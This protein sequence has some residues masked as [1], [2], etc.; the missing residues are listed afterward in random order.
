MHCVKRK[1]GS[2]YVRPKSAKPR[3]DEPEGEECP[4]D[5]QL[6]I[7]FSLQERVALLDALRESRKQ[8]RDAL[9]ITSTATSDPKIVKMVRSEIQFL[10][11]EITRKEKILSSLRATKQ[12]PAVKQKITVLEE[13]IKTNNNELRTL[14]ASLS[15]QKNDSP[16]YQ[17]VEKCSEL[18]KR[19]VG[20]QQY[21][22]EL[23]KKYSVLDIDRSNAIDESKS[24]FD[25]VLAIFERSVLSLAKADDDIKLARK[26]INALKKNRDDYAKLAED[27]V[28]KL[29]R[30]EQKVVYTTDTVKLREK[31]IANLKETSEQFQSLAKNAIDKLNVQE[32]KLV[33]TLLEKDDLAK[34]LEASQLEAQQAIIKAS[35]CEDELARVRKEIDDTLRALQEHKHLLSDATKRQ[36]ELQQQIEKHIRKNMQSQNQIKMYKKAI[37]KYVL[38]H[39]KAMR[40]AKQSYRHLQNF[41][42]KAVDKEQTCSKLRIQDTLFLDEVMSLLQNQKELSK[43]SLCINKGE[44][45]Q[46]CLYK[47]LDTSKQSYAAAAQQS[48]LEQD[49]MDIENEYQQL[50]IQTPVQDSKS[51]V[52]VDQELDNMWNAI[53]ESSNLEEM[54]EDWSPQM[55]QPIGSQPQKP[56]QIAPGVGQLALPS[57]KK[58]YISFDLTDEDFMEEDEEEKD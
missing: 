38:E 1:D 27:V 13:E 37:K 55:L 21:Y 17:R 45:F 11:Y 8:L 19:L 14:Y 4:L 46:Q 3:E 15:T 2:Y 24:T 42:D 43:F 53:Q 57:Q 20:L 29:N 51:D 56:M 10:Q 28:D 25:Q 23:L 44:A 52:E 22:G 12:T 41:L 49:L 6:S 7:A 54:L 48:Q 47:S 18:E 50:Q 32:S 34:R 40:A 36:V 30:Q 16:L 35:Q 33:K 39:N 9:L 58:Q 31:E 5:V 26:E